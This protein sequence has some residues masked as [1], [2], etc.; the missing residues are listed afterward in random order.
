M[1]KY[2]KE[3][4]DEI[5]KEKGYFGHNTE[6]N[7]KRYLSKI[8]KLCSENGRTDG[9]IFCEIDIVNYY[10][11]KITLPEIAARDGLFRENVLLYILTTSPMP[12]ECKFN[13]SKDQLTIEWHY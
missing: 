4:A 13:K 12:T 1:K 3:K 5:L 10:T 6:V 2:W 11:I 8:E 9:I 7:I